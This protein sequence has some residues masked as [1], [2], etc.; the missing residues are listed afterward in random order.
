MN[1]RDTAA[2][3]ANG[4]QQKEKRKAILPLFYSRKGTRCWPHNTWWA[5]HCI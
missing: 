2:C 3:P 1:H 4:Y 5:E